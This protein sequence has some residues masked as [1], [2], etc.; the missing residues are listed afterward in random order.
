MIIFRKLFTENQEEKPKVKD[1]IRKTGH[2]AVD[3][4]VDN[5]LDTAA[6]LVG[7]I[8]LPGKLAKEAA[9][10]WK[11]PKGKLAAGALGVYALSP[12]GATT[13]AIAYK[14]KRKKK[15]AEEKQFSNLRDS[16]SEGIS[17][18][19]SEKNPRL[20]EYLEH[21]KEKENEDPRLKKINRK[22]KQ[23][24]KFKETWKP[25]IRESDIKFASP[26]D[27][28][29]N[30]NNWRGDAQRFYDGHVYYQKPDSYE[31]DWEDEEE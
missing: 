30:Y 24:L 1:K 14:N 7:D 22:A 9:K 12:F 21:K 2:K 29:K 10:K 18:W 6:W 3:Y 11:G 27:P 31:N 13:A 28:P 19:A 8:I 26:Y 15:K 16:I 23:P 20:K 4:V 5:P 17:D 25:E